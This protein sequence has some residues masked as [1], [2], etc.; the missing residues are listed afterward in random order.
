MRLREL[1]AAGVAALMRVMPASAAEYNWSGSYVGAVVSGGL[2]TLEQEDYWCDAACNVPTQQ[3]WAASIGVQAGHNWQNGNFVYGLVVDWSTG[4]EETHN[5]S[6]NDGDSR[7]QF[8]GEWNSY[9]TLRARGGLAVGNVLLSGSAGIAIVDVDYS[10]RYNSSYNISGFDCADAECTDVSDTLV[11]FAGGMSL[12]YPVGD[13]MHMNFDYLYIGL[14]SESDLYNF[15][16]PSSEDD[17]TVTSTTS[18]HLA[19]VSLVYEF[20]GL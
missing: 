12:S 6:W 2:F 11:G 15:E 16:D 18:A 19:R 1:L 10:S 17:D 9:A 14:P 13:N 3:D 7:A 4:F 5:A 8:S 20:D